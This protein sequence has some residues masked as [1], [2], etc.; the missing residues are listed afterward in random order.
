MVHRP[1]A[2]QNTLGHGTGL[3]HHKQL[4]LGLEK[5]TVDA[6]GIGVYNPGAGDPQF[7]SER[8][9]L[10]IHSYYILCYFTMLLFY[11]KCY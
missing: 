4:Y 6:H 10:L 9:I 5:Q 7:N 1:E 11:N 8:S 3:L 2:K